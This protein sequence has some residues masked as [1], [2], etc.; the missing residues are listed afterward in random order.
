MEFD[1]FNLDTFERVGILDS[2]EKAETETNYYDHNQL[3]LLLDATPEMIELF[4]KQSEDIFLTLSN[5]RRQAFLVEKV[6]YSDDTNAQ[7]EVVGYSLSYMLSW[8]QIDRQQTFKGDVVAVLRGFVDKNAINPENSKRKLP[9]LVTSGANSLGITTEESYNNKPLDESLWE[10]CEKLEISW[11]IIVNLANKQFEFVVWKGVNR[12]TEQMTVD[13]VIFSKQ[14]ENVLSQDFEDDKSDFKNT[15]LIAGEGQGANRVFLLV[16]DE[17]AGRKRREM[18]VDARDLQSEPESEE[19][20]MTEAEYNALLL[21][22]AANKLAERQRIQSYNSEI[23]F[24]S[25]FKF[26]ADYFTGDTVTIRNDEIGVML[27]TIVV[28]AT[29]SYSKNGK[30]LK[31]S[32]GSDTPS[33]FE[34]IKKKVVMN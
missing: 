15:V 12:S 5:D 25:Q 4:I 31:I 8:R 17:N 16:G 2:Y 3:E 11:D 32:F 19:D 18:F 22:R 23:A 26:G 10:I 20:K 9:N 6:K 29:E 13:P 34:K 27:H 24:D 28:S 7:I 30:E 21:Q 33:L 14:F 1:V